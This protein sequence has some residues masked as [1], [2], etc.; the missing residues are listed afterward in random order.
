MEYVI[1][2]LVWFSTIFGGEGP[3][4]AGNPPGIG[5]PAHATIRFPS[6]AG[7]DAFARRMVAMTIEHNVVAPC[8]P[9]PSQ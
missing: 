2:I 4:P 7:C 3:G 1:V 5:H 9:V 8:T 6:K